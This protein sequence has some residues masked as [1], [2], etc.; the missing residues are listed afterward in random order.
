[1]TT[2]E[3]IMAKLKEAGLPAAV[4]TDTHQISA[5]GC[6]LIAADQGWARVV[7]RD[8]RGIRLIGLAR[9]APSETMYE[10][11]PAGAQALEEL[12]NIWDQA[13]SAMQVIS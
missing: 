11:T 12:S 6:L 3:S 4:P 7:G 1:P 5:G 2:A 13:G 8:V 9:A 10:I